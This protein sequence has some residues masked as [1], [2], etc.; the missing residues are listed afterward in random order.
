[1]HL[2]MRNETETSN[3]INLKVKKQTSLAINNWKLKLKKNTFKV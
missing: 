3:S 2:V 1:M